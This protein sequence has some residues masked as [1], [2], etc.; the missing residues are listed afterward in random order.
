MIWISAAYQFVKG[1]RTAQIALA[2]LVLA[3]VAAGL[4]LWAIQAQRQAVKDATASGR[5]IQQRD[6]LHETLNRTL[7]AINA[8]EAVRHNPAVRDAACLRHARN[9]EDC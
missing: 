3:A 8:E 2:V 1:S 4:Y 6:D 7:E 9:P 5:A